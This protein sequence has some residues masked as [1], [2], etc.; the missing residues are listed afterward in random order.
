MRSLEVD[1]AQIDRAEN[2]FRTRDRERL[3]AQF[4]SGDPRAARDHI[5]TQP[6]RDGMDQQ[7]GERQ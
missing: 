5:I 3:L 1:E 2:L 4:E 6:P 7:E